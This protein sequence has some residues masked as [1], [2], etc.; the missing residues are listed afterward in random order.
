MNKTRPSASGNRSECRSI[1]T[2]SAREVVHDDVLSRN[3]LTAAKALIHGWQALHRADGYFV[4]YVLA[5]DA[6][7]DPAVAAR[8]GKNEMNA[9]LMPLA[10]VLPNSLL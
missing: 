4:A 10:T 7:G 9:G 2:S 6:N 1:R 3:G 8:S 5:V